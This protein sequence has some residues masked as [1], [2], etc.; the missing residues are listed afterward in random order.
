MQI[1]NQYYDMYAI[2]ITII[3]CSK[4]FMIKI[5][6]RR[7]YS[8]EPDMHITFFFAV[9]LYHNNFSLGMLYL[10]LISKQELKVQH[11]WMKITTTHFINII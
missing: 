5:N 10:A 4:Y 3:A 7:S 8:L 9:V 2:D 6:K 1:L 11:T